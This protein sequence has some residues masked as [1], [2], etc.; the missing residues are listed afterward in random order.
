MDGIV[1]LP[2][3]ERPA[4]IRFDQSAVPYIQAGSQL[5]VYLAQGYVVASERIFQM[6]ML[7]RI[8][9][10]ELSEIFGASCLP[11]D[12]LARTIG[13][14][15]A[16]RKEFA[17]LSP[18]TKG[19]LKA[20][21]A[22]INS[23]I[24]QNVSHLPLEFIL[25]GYHPRMWQPQDTLAI[26]K[27]LQYSMDESWR[28]DEF[29]ERLI[30]K[31]G[32]TL[33][34]L[35]FEHNFQNQT[36]KT[37]ALIPP[38][39]TKLSNTLFGNSKLGLGSNGWIVGG[40]ISN[41]QAC[42]LACDKHCLFTAPDLWYMCSLQ[43]PGLHAAGL[44]IPGIPGVILGRNQNIAWAMTHLKAD[45]QDLFVEQF[46]DKYPNKY[47]TPDG[48]SDASET[49]EE[50]VQRFSSSILEKIVETRHGPILIKNDT[51]GVALSWTG[52]Q[53]KGSVIDTIFALQKAN[54]WEEF[55]QILKGYD[56]S[57]QTFLYADRQG[58][59][60]TQVAG[61]IIL[62]KCDRQMSNTT[63]SEGARL[64]PGFDD[65][66]SWQE[67]IRFEAMPSNLNCDDGFVV[68]NDPRRDFISTNGNNAS[69]QR[70]LS[71][72]SDYKTNGHHPDLAE[73]SVLQ[74]DEMA[75]LANLLRYEITTALKN[76]QSVD[77]YSLRAQAALTKWDGQ[78][79]GVSNCACIYESF[80]ATFL[81]RVLEPK[82]GRDLTNEYAQRWPRWTNFVAHVLREKPPSLL[83]PSE[84]SYETLVLNSLSESLKNLRTS[85]HSE[86][87]GNW[88]WKTL[89]QIDFAEYPMHLGLPAFLV[90]LFSPTKIGVGGDQD[91]V[92]ACNVELNG[93][94][95]CFSSMVGPAARLVIDL[96][97]QEKF[98]QSLT[99][100][101][102]EHLLSNYR[103][104]QFKSWLNVEPRAVAFSDRQIQLQMQHTLILSNTYQ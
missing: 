7:R 44:A 89:H 56:G 97:D 4:R 52:L 20:Y 58:N 74:G 73:M 30:N 31:A 32:T 47:R 101:Q 2:D 23:Y 57:P 76:T 98:Y 94:P 85:L 25:L 72:L 95:W 13:F 83:P 16:A 68:A 29:R 35:M 12:K 103:T 15:R 60:A 41:S 104:E 91:C 66:C 6:D 36:L 70:I 37:D 14:N 19:F 54:T 81:R 17:A 63:I 5:D 40:G 21:C 22:G 53:N 88:S 38:I 75:A 64:L 8:A 90:Q 49:T 46:S 86:Q 10:G 67:T 33:A 1:S 99:L 92:N 51:V 9:K 27:F 65:K 24:N 34:S 79:R 96:N 69:A 11:H 26:L 43:G 45:V 39:L 55:R 93:V 61:T 87:I 82:I 48:W 50:I 78:L 18:M 100:G 84:R 71:V 62:R 28:L 59:F 102:S 3:L 42:L 80:L 77:E